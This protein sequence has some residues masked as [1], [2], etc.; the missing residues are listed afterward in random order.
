M[1]RTPTPEQLAELQAL[2]AMTDDTIDTSDA[3]EVTDWSGAVQGR[4]YRPV[5]QQVTIR[6]D[7]DVLEYFKQVAARAGVRGAPRGYQTRINSALRE[8]VAKKKGGHA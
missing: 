8:Y 6:I 4:F 2:A 7:A 3:P 1:A 5:K